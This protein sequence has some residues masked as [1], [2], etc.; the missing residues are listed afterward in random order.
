[1][2]TEDIEQWADEFTA[3]HTRFGHLF[4]RSESREQAVKYLR[5]LLSSVERKN[6]WQMAEAVGDA[7][8][9]RMQRL[10]YRS[11][12]DYEAARDILQTFIIETLGDPE[13]IAVVD[14]TGFLKK[15]ND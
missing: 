1:M 3:F 6:S 4:S 14:E 15:G 7:I 11:A 8:P 12:W 5:G 2:T 10:L 13:G 9:D